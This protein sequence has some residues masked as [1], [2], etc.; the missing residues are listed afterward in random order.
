MTLDPQLEISCEQNHHDDAT[1]AHHEKTIP[2]QQPGSEQTQNV[3]DNLPPPHPSDST[4][5]INQ[6]DARYRHGISR[7]SSLAT[8]RKTPSNGNRSQAPTQ[9]QSRRSS[10]RSTA[11]SGISVKHALVPNL[12][13]IYMDEPLFPYTDSPKLVA[14][15]TD[16]PFALANGRSVSHTP[17][18]NRRHSSITNQLQLFK[19]IKVRDSN[20]SKMINRPI[21][22]HSDTA[23]RD[24]H[25]QSQRNLLSSNKQRPSPRNAQL[26]SSAPVTNEQKSDIDANQVPNPAAAAAAV[27]V[28][29]FPSPTAAQTAIKYPKLRIQT[30]SADDDNAPI[31]KHYKYKDDQDD[32]R[33]ANNSTKQ[34]KLSSNRT[35]Q[36]S[37]HSTANSR[38]ATPK[39]TNAPKSHFA[40]FRKL[41]MITPKN[42]SRMIQGITDADVRRESLFDRA[43]YERSA[44]LDATAQKPSFLSRLIFNQD[45]R[46]SAINRYMSQYQPG[47][48]PKANQTPFQKHSPN[49]NAKLSA[50]QF[51]AA[52][53]N[54]SLNPDLNTARS[55]NSN[56]I[57]LD[58]EDDGDAASEQAS[59]D[60]NNRAKAANLSDD[61]D[62]VDDKSV[63]QQQQQDEDQVDFHRRETSQT[64]NQQRASV[65]NL[66]QQQQQQQH[67]ATRRSTFNTRNSDN[68]ISFPE[69]E[70][71][72]ANYQ[73]DQDNNEEEWTRQSSQPSD[74][75]SGF[76]M[77]PRAL[78][79]HH[80]QQ[81][82]NRSHRAL[83]RLSQLLDFDNV[84]ESSRHYPPGA[85]PRSLYALSK[86]AKDE[87]KRHLSEQDRL[88]LFID[89]ESMTPEEAR[90]T[91]MKIF[92]KGLMSTGLP[93]HA[94][95]FYTTLTGQ[96]LGL[97]LNLVSINSACVMTFNHDS[98][99]HLVT[100]EYTGFS[101]AKMVEICHVSEEIIRGQLTYEDAIL[102]VQSVVRS[103]PLY[104]S[105]LFVPSFALVSF[106]A[107]PLFSGSITEMLCGGLSGAFVA[108]MD[109]YSLNHL[110]IARGHDIIGGILSSIIAVI[111][112][113]YVAPINV[114][115][116]V[117]SGIIWLMP[118]LR[119]T[120][121]MIDLSTGHP[122]SGTSKFMAGIISALNLGLGVTA[123]SQLSILIGAG[124]IDLL[125]QAS[126]PLPDWAVWL[127]V[128]FITLPMMV[129][130]DCKP[131]HLPQL[132]MGSFVAFALATITTEYIGSAFSTWFASA[133]IGII[134]NIYGRFTR[135]PS[136]ELVL[137]SVML[138]LP[139]SIG[140]RSILA[141]SDTL[142]SINFFF[143]MFTAAF[144]IVTG[145]FT[146]NIILPPL[147]VT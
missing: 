28:R 116:A 117:F 39:K 46:S 137:F 68:S 41:S 65:S 92:V 14:R 36:S 132:L 146:A 121:A 75:T 13:P 38:L 119:F 97:Y 31:E 26:H 1:A 126:F 124:P 21:D 139:G 77:T 71:S 6:D 114:L 128:L 136:I 44:Q 62:N 85:D 93:L 43:I 102:S 96:R 22:V 140:V 130:C 84:S 56:I 122:V 67:Q 98:Q 86:I 110:A 24:N 131:T 29:I 73:G 61:Q 79:K 74:F 147:R 34:G 103:K 104:A 118:G 112:H 18:E 76:G 134:A 108:V 91:F 129:L 11:T 20:D 42:I 9:N 27:A 144:A 45:R 37:K 90:N 40:A 33:Q 47:D 35:S 58:R 88:E 60:N 54:R 138:L 100:P 78:D 145:L 50:S 12:T 63:Y 19:G 57:N 109:Q 113:T 142:S 10:I 99:S 81:Q 83:R 107:A 8:C 105:W 25:R 141:G 2:E 51:E 115:A 15:A 4:Q 64:M 125:H 133:S 17:F 32:E 94:V 120:M 80:Q 95:E 70:Q 59:L 23:N 52:N 106:L 7:Q 82:N 87:K 55:S 5:K 72:A 3:P 135:N 66:S 69:D 49:P 101:L 16:S 127:C 143:Q 48:T 123:G 53:A 111:C 89:V 30:S